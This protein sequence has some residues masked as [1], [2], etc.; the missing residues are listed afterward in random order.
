[1][2]SI[3]GAG[4]DPADPDVLQRVGEEVE[5]A[6][7]HLARVEQIKKFTLL[8]TAWLPDSDELTPTLKLKR[9]PIA[10]K[11][12]AEIEALYAHD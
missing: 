3:P 11:Y 12:A 7:E 10:A 2:T 4:L 5:H 6:N 8:G 1:M 9:R